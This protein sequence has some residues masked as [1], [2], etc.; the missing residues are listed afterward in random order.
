MC[1]AFSTVIQD[2]FTRKGKTMALTV[3]QTSPLL[4]SGGVPKLGP[5]LFSIRTIKTVFAERLE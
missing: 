2:P 1:F 3:L 4:S 5:S